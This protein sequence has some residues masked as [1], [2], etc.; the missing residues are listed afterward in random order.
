MSSRKWKPVELPAEFRKPEGAYSPALRA[1]PFILLSGQVPRDLRSGQVVGG[2]VQAQARAVLENVQA[3]LEAAGASM[4][5]VV[6]VTAYLADMDDWGAFDEVYRSFFRE[7]R[8]T[9][10]T[11]GAEL[12]GFLVEVSVVAYTG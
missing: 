7:P 6:S 2:D 3:L 5:D 4:A 12:K 11:V 8:P 9:R 10:T 1:G